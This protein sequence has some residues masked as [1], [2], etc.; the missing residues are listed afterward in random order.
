M[1]LQI[2]GKRTPKT[3]ADDEDELKQIA[4]EQVAY[5]EEI[6][7]DLLSFS[8]PDA[9]KLEWVSID[10]LLDKTIIAS[11]RSI[12]QHHVR[13]ISSYQPGLPML[14]ADP[15]KLRQAFTNL[16]INAVQATDNVAAGEIEV[17][18][19]LEIG[20]ERPLVRIEISD[21][22][23]GID[24]AQ[25]EKLFE[26]FFT[27]RAKGTGLGLPIVRRIIEQHEGSIYLESN[28]DAGTRAVVLLPTG[29]AVDVDGDPDSRRSSSE[30]AIQSEDNLS[31]VQ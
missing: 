24:P 3:A 18:A 19:R 14:H 25:C 27:T 5:M 4:L 20:A 30:D 29:L 10:K 1:G 26:P 12:E 17:V 9:L 16:I 11:Q 6:L 8:R 2:L 7:D 23:G 15:R 28:Q 31:A 22:G 13:V 21:N